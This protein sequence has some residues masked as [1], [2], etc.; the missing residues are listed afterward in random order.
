MLKIVKKSSRNVFDYLSRFADYTYD[1]PTRVAFMIFFI[2]GIGLRILNFT[3]YTNIY[4][5]DEIFQSLEPAHQLVFG[6]AYLPPEFRTSVPGSDYY[7]RARSWLFPLI[8]AIPMYLMS[9]MG[10][11]YHTQIL[12]TLY[13]IGVISSILMILSAR[14]FLAVYSGNKKIGDMGAVILSVTPHIAY[15]TSRLTTN[16]LLLPLLFFSLAKA[17][18]IHR[19]GEGTIN[20]RNIKLWEKITLVFGLGVVTYIRMD[21][22]IIITGISILELISFDKGRFR[23]KQP[24]VYMEYLILGT[25]G[26]VFGMVVDY[27]L[28]N[29]NSL[30][31]LWQVPYNWFGFNFI[32]QGSRNFGVSVFGTY[33]LT[34]I[35]KDGSW[36]WIFLSSVILTIVFMVE[37]YYRESIDPLIIS[38][39]EKMIDRAMKFLKLSS[40]LFFTWI[41]Y[42][43]PFENGIN[44]YATSHKETRFIINVL[45]LYRLFMAYSFCLGIE[46][47]DLYFTFQQFRKSTV[48]ISKIGFTSLYVKIIVVVLVIFISLP[49]ITA[50]E[51]MLEPYAQYGDTNNA[52]RWIGQQDDV[53]GVIVLVNWF[54]SGGYTYLHQNVSM[55]FIGD[56]GETLYL[57][58]A[59]KVS[60]YNYAL[61][62]KFTYGKNGALFNI[63][64]DNGWVIANVIDG[65][66]EVWVRS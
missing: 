30:T 11:D 53:R 31:D 65:N 7:G 6:Y 62:P 15:A 48:L 52:L 2:Y 8:F 33:Y 4:H 20:P 63:L 29:S 50:N 49:M 66:S 38:R 26:W 17:V 23:I 18:Q 9:K 39:R 32:E 22:L 46:A 35:S 51:R 34:T 14:Y 54:Y 58:N 59:L 40:V 57:E 42:E 41:I 19:S 55:L 56:V 1:N 61:V 36:I 25:I 47:L 44:F 64:R 24:K 28:Y 5:P 16:T 45:I 12:P 43:W 10:F 60:A 27:R 13:F 21:L 37:L 3:Y